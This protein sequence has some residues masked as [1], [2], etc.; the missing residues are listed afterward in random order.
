MEVGLFFFGILYLV[1]RFTND[2]INKIK[3]SGQPKYPAIKDMERFCRDKI[4]HG[5]KYAEM[6]WQNGD[7]S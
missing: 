1:V 5:D 2:S 4:K 6:K 3:N 7:Y